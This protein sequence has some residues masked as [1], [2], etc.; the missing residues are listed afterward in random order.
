MRVFFPESVKK[1]LVCSENNE[2]EYED[3]DQVDT[4]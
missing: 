2:S 4:H 3:K 1:A